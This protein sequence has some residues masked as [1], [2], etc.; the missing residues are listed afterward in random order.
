MLLYVAILTLIVWYLYRFYS[1][2]SD[3]PPGPLPIPI[4]GNLLSFVGIDRWEDKL[5]EWKQKYGDVFT[6][7]IGLQRFVTVNSYKA[8]VKYFVKDGDSYTDRLRNGVNE[9]VRG[10]NYGVVETGGHL[11]LEQRRFALKVLR[12]FGLSKA[13]M[14]QRV[15]DEVEYILNQIDKHYTDIAVGSVINAVL[16]GYR[17]TDGNEAEFYHLKK[18][19]TVAT[20]RFASIWGTFLVFNTELFNLRILKPFI[21]YVTEMMVQ[22]IDNLL[23]QIEDHKKNNDY[24]NQ[25]T[26][27]K[28]FV[29]AYMI[30][31]YR[32]EANG[33]YDTT[34]SEKQL[35]NVCFHLWI[36]GQETTSITLTWAISYMVNHPETQQKAQDELD[37]VIG[38]N[39]LIT[40]ADRKDLHYVNAFVNEAQRCANILPINLPRRT[41]KDV[42]IDGKLLPK[43]T[44]VFPQI[45]TIMHDPEVFD[46]PSTFNPGRFIDENGRFKQIEE[47]VP[48]SIGKRACLGEGLARMELFLITANILNRYKLSVG[49]QPPSVRRMAGM[50]ARLNPFNSH[51]E[52][53]Q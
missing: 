36:A 28:D 18:V 44:I 21:T 23:K 47:V 40:M 13:Q 32:L 53:R 16:F 43:G 35:A 26:E 39:R 27:A 34:F 33:E 30:E 3:L 50:M 14:E 45:S 12:D 5:V 46:S 8:A 37:R 15:L 48:F 4:V 22:I 17:Y 1:S 25:S 7:H 51:V 31:K 2:L 10:G 38:S 42:E 24:S 29:D 49:D 19:L 6:I 41:T 9:I 11:W 20:D 52:L